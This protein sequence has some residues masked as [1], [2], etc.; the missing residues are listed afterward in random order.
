MSKGENVLV[1][2]WIGS[3]RDIKEW[4][5][6]DVGSSFFVVFKSDVKNSSC[7]PSPTLSRRHHTKTCRPL[8]PP[9]LGRALPCMGDPYLD[10]GF[11]YDE[12][13]RTDI[14]NSPF[15]D[16]SFGAD[17]T[18]DE[19]LD[20][21]LYRLTLALEEHIIPGDWI[22]I[23][24]PPPPP[25]PAIFPT[26]RILRVSVLVVRVVRNL[27]QAVGQEVLVESKQK[28][29]Y[30]FL[31]DLPIGGLM[32]ATSIMNSRL[33]SAE[34]LREKRVGRGVRVPFG[35]ATYYP[36]YGEC[37][38]TSSSTTATSTPSTASQQC[39]NFKAESTAADYSLLHEKRE[40]ILR[41]KHKYMTTNESVV[42]GARSL[43]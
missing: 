36:N 28:L 3:K 6:Q 37:L 43:F 40:T 24:H 11:E 19:Y 9:L 29:G 34:V 2:G 35:V 27:R 5:I 7:S 30:Y 13:G 8:S 26:L 18:A 31:F 41:F 1:G 15:F 39:R 22:I 17:P 32:E 16:V 10:A 12:E 21:I 14:L 42:K 33:D 38:P 20:R 25:H 4:G 23:G